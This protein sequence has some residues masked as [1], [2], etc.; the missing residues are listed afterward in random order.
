MVRGLDI[1]KTVASYLWTQL[2]DGVLHHDH[3]GRYA[4]DNIN[5]SYLQHKIHF[6]HMCIANYQ[7]RY[8]EYTHF[9]YLWP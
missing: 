6:D 5:C 8:H 2:I 7:E 9:S 1:Y 3:V 4:V